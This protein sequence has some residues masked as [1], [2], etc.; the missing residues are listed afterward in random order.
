MYYVLPSIRP[1][2]IL[3]YDETH[4]EKEGGMVSRSGYRIKFPRDKS[5][6]FSGNRDTP[7][8]NPI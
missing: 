2:R 3:F 6:L 4:I 7:K 8:Y 1:E 5:A